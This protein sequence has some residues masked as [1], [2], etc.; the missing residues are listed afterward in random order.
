MEGSESVLPPAVRVDSDV[1]PLLLPAGDK[2]IRPGLESNGVWEPEEAA[3]IRTLVEP[4][5]TV[6]DVGAHCG[7][8]TLM[9]SGLVGPGG[10]VVALEPAPDNHA[11]LRANVEHSGATNVRVLN[12]AGWR[13]SGE[14]IPLSLSDTNSGDHR[15]YRWSSGRPFVE[16]DGI[17]IDDL[18]P[19]LDRLD[20]VKLD[21]Q[22][23]EHVVIEGMRSTIERCRPVALTEFWPIS[24]RE[25]G[26]RPEDV[27][28][29]YRGL[30]FEIAVIEDESVA[31]DASDAE[32]IGLAGASLTEFVTLV[33][34]PAE[35]GR[36]A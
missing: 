13:S 20:L 32:L 5:A 10:T 22:G 36:P 26:D 8:F 33:L 9:M 12:A 17:A 6:L 30:G 34:R 27:L 15:S 2:V 1:G 35:A 16:V 14:R 7:Y 18:D 25:L 4:G 31:P 29:L 3:V 24:I 11:L 23:T 28:A 21:T 19:A